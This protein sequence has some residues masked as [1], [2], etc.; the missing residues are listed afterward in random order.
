M[1]GFSNRYSCPEV[2]LAI[3]NVKFIVEGPSF[4][5]LWYEVEEP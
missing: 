4:D 1:V 2:R 3:S 5:E